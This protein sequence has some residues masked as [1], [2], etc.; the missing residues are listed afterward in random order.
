MKWPWKK[1]EAAQPPAISNLKLSDIEQ[2]MEMF[3]GGDSV[4]GPLVNYMTAMRATAVYA[5][6]RLIAGTIGMLPANVYQKADGGVRQ[7]DQSHPLYPILHDQPNPVMSGPVFWEAIMTGALLLG[8]GYALIRRKGRNPDPVGLTWLHPKRVSVYMVNGRLKYHIMV[9]DTIS[10]DSASWSEGGIPEVV[11]QDDMLHIPGVGWDGV[12]GMS[13][14]AWAGRRAIGSALATDEHSAL[15]FSQGAKPDFALK[16]PKALSKEQADMLR[17][18]WA[19]KVAGLSNAHTPA[20]LTEGGEVQQLTMSAEDSQLLQTRMFNVIDIARMFGV[21]PH[22]IGETTKST[23]WGT[24]IE[25]Q[26]MGFLTYTLG[27]WLN[28]IESESRRKLFRGDFAGHFMR[29]E[30]DALLHADSKTRND[31]YNI[32]RG[33]TQAPAYMTINEI[34]RKENLP[35]IEGGDDLFMPP[36]AGEG[37]QNDQQPPNQPEPDPGDPNEPPDEPAHG[38]ALPAFPG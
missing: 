19:R 16:Y 37:G 14:V 30:R 26:N 6:V 23:S 15:F 12:R 28:K 11:D 7:E 3:G 31:A 38:P 32:A 33:G 5:C 27:P 9:D 34:R 18:Y 21:P 13:V 29:F 36:G 17:E 25:Q 8:N 1:T 24:G 20:I 2:W 10:P 22:M 35:P 4:A